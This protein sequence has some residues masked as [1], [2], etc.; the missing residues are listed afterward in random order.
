MKIVT[1]VG[2]RPQFIKCSPVSEELRKDHKE[3]LIHTGQ[4]YDNEMSGLFFDELKIPKPDY[5]LG[6]GSGLHGEQ[7]GE[8]LIDLE[9][10]LIKIKPDIVLIYGDTNS[11]VAGAL[12]A[13]K[14]HIPIGH[15]ESGLRSFDKFMPE[16]INRIVA[17]HVSNILFV[18]TNTGVDNLKNEGITTGVYHIGD[19]MYD[20]LLKNIKIAKDKSSIL[21]RLNVKPKDY[22]LLT[23]HRPSNTDNK[24]SLSDIMSALSSFEKKIIFP[25]HPRTLKFLKNYDL[26]NKIG[27]NIIITKPLGYL[28]F[29]L[30]E[31]NAKKILT[32]SGGIQ[33][34]AYLLKVPCI[35]LRRN[36]EWIETVNDEWNVLVGSDSEK[37]ID[38]VQNFLPKKN[39]K[40]YFGEGIASKEIRE[41]L[42]KYKF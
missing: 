23:I 1:I 6:I 2:A 31:K 36:T 22:F 8:M 17:D 32:D 25:V 40:N 41:I 42:E 14:L 9:K 39:Q 4:H 37:I 33:K 10:L 11:T 20:A 18:P 21:E 16:E 28:D 35:T 3:I 26:L 15:I 7:T 5:N 34:E 38:A 19:V 12:A 24:K 27:E 29:I 13:A 30:L